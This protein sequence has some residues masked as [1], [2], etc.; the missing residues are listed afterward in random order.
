M[1]EY[2]ARCL[3]AYE[4]ECAEL[5]ARLLREARKRVPKPINK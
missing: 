3:A 2:E 5:L 1:T 4:W